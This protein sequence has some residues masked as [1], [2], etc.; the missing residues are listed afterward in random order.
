MMRNTRQIEV[1]GELTEKSH[2]AILK[3]AAR[4]HR[5]TPKVDVKGESP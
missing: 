2:V 4:A 1:S 5:G 3:T